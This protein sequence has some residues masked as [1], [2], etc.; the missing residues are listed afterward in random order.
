M[1]N[2]QRIKNFN[3]FT[4][5][6]EIWVSYCTG[7]NGE[8]Y[9]ERPMYNEMGEVD[10]EVANIMFKANESAEEVID[11]NEVLEETIVSDSVALVPTKTGEVIVYNTPENSE[12]DKGFM[13]KYG[14]LIGVGLAGILI[15]ASIVALAKGCENDK[16][17]VILPN[18]DADSTIEQEVETIKYITK[19]EYIDGVKTFTQSL[20]TNYGFTYQ[21]S[22]L[23]SFYYVANME[24]ISDELFADLVKEGYIPDTISKLL[25]NTFEVTGSVRTKNLQTGIS[26]LDYEK[27]FVDGN[28]AEVA[29]TWEAKY[30]ACADLESMPA[31][32]AE[33]ED[34]VIVSPESGYNELPTGGREIFNWTIGESI[35]TKAEFNGVEATTALKEESAD[36]TTVMTVYS[37]EF[38]CIVEEAEKQLTK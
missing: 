11:E 18:P 14:H 5:D 31:V 25:V 17:H 13:D 24:N 36:M 6:G 9:H 33:L 10:P 16:N 26:N 2:N 35:Y 22:Q 7:E 20:N 23:T 8:N 1:E 38:A 28:M 32:L 29:E 15:G 12:L 37:N 3:T 19:D 30:N 4:K 27:L 34:F 21:P